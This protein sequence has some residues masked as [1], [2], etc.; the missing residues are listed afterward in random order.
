VRSVL[1]LMLL[2]CCP[3]TCRLEAIVLHLQLPPTWRLQE[4]G[5]L[6]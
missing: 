4:V 1:C 3:A 6:F 5:L 2:Q